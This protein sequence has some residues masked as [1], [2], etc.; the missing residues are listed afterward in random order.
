MGIIYTPLLAT[1]LLE[2]YKGKEEMMNGTW[3]RLIYGRINPPAT[4]VSRRAVIMG[5]VSAITGTAIGECAV[6]LAR[7]Q[8]KPFPQ[9]M[10]FV[11][12]RGHSSAVRSARWSPDGKYIVSA[13]DDETVQVWNADDGRQILTYGG[14][15]SLVYLAAWS[16]DGKRIA[17]ASGDGTVQVW[18]ADDG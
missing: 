13:S 16:P 4:R 5:V 8:W 9:G 18:N 6:L 7:Q 11:T 15:S 10:L 3:Q 2:I 1:Q 17:S 14:H 12:Y